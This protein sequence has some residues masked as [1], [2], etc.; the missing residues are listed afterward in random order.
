MN[1]TSPTCASDYFINDNSTTIIPQNWTHKSIPNINPNSIINSVSFKWRPIHRIA[2]PRRAKA[3]IEESWIPMG[4]WFICSRSIAL[5]REGAEWL[6][7]NGIWTRRLA[8]R[9]KNGKIRA[10][11]GFSWQK[12]T[13]TIYGE[14]QGCSEPLADDVKAF[15]RLEGSGL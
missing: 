4:D 15:I 12:K 2:N 14:C 9:C 7:S 5:K 8:H 11:R 1:Y 3:I 6:E 10:P 13:D